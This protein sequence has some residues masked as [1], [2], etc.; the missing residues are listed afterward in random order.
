MPWSLAAFNDELMVGVSGEGCRVLRAPYLFPEKPDGTP[1]VKDMN[2]DGRW[3]Y[4][5][6]TGNVATGY[7]D[8][9]GTSNYLNGFD[10]YQYPGTTSYQNLAVNLFTFR[11]K[12]YGGTISQ[13]APE[14]NIPADISQLKGAQIWRTTNGLTWTPVTADGFGDSNIINF[15]AFTDFGGTLYVSGSKGASATPVAGRSKNF[16]PGGR[17]LRERHSGSGSCRR[18]SALYSN[19]YYNG[20]ART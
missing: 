11:D 4:S 10:A 8:P 18:I 7:T 15:E 19:G 16:S 12:L 14:Y 2:G 3:F 6:G 5:V 13:Y 1:I 9:L 20:A 17:A